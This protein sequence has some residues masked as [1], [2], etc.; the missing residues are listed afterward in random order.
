MIFLLQNISVLKSSYSYSHDSISNNTHTIIMNEIS[1]CITL[2]IFKNNL[3]MASVSPYK[4]NDNTNLNVKNRT[5][6]CYS[7][8]IK[9]KIKTLCIRN[10][11]SILNYCRCIIWVHTK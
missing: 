5:T 10:C 8:N 1:P 7:S 4:I 11:L 3:K 6:L 2:I 9:I